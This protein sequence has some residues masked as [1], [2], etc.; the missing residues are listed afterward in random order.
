[1]RRLVAKKILARRRARVQRH[2]RDRIGVLRPVAVHHQ[3]D[4]LEEPLQVLELLHRADELLE[5]FQPSGGVGRAVAL[6]HVGVARLVEHDLDQLG[7]GQDVALA[8]A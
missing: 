2:D 1:M 7:M 3:R 5:V 6:P 4:V 8:R